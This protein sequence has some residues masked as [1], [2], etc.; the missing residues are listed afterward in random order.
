MLQQKKVVKVEGRDVLTSDGKLQR[1]IGNNAVFPG[2]FVW[3]DGE[4]VYGNLMQRGTMS[5]AVFTD[6]YVLPLMTN[7]IGEKNQTVEY[8]I[9]L[10]SLNEVYPYTFFPREGNTGAFACTSSFYLTTTHDN[11]LDFCV[12][13]TAEQDPPPARLV[14]AIEN[15]TVDEYCETSSYTLHSYDYKDVGNYALMTRYCKEYT[16]IQ[17]NDKVD[18]SGSETK[19]ILDEEHEAYHEVKEFTF[20]EIETGSQ[21]ASIVTDDK[22]VIKI[23]GNDGVVDLNERILNTYGK[24]FTGMLAKD[25]K[26]KQPS[27]TRIKTEIVDGRINNDGYWMIRVKSKLQATAYLSWRYDD[28]YTTVREKRLDIVTKLVDVGFGMKA[29]YSKLVNGTSVIFERMDFQGDTFFSYQ[30]T[31][32]FLIDSNN[33]VTMLKR[34][35]SN[36]KGDM[37]GKEVEN[38]I[39]I[40]VHG[41][42]VEKGADAPNLAAGEF[43]KVEDG[44]SDE[45]VE[46]YLNGLEAEYDRKVIRERKDYEYRRIYRHVDKNIN[47]VLENNGGMVMNLPLG[48]G[49][50]AQLAIHPDKQALFEVVMMYD[51]AGNAYDDMSGYAL[52]C[53]GF[54][55]VEV[56]RGN[57]FFLKAY[58]DA[59]NNRRQAYVYSRRDSGNY[60]Y[61][62]SHAA[63]LT[64]RISVMQKRNMQNGALVDW[65]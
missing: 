23:H 65:G 57:V 21:A 35:I 15:G 18:V 62:Q 12:A 1:I 54:L 22:A 14:N 30:E 29:W 39:D 9:D 40:P 13:D 5:P 60:H 38:N 17:R 19:V 63:P 33:N 46:I 47:L 27:I 31:I 8:Y 55:D 53:I 48:K 59:S 3:A 7:S 20:S 6:K 43:M 2:D 44:C 32:D 25:Y 51:A 56:W 28:S 11:L 64:S 37:T 24:E 52:D 50:T 34:E 41:E 42:W 10:P 45:E 4:V 36:L 61:L 58:I 26:L 16:Q 49:N